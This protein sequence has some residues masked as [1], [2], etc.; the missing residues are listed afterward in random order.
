MIGVQALQAPELV[1]GLLI[2]EYYLSVVIK[3]CEPGL[4]VCGDVV[5]ALSMTEDLTFCIS[6]NCVRRHY[7]LLMRL[8]SN[9]SMS[10][11]SNSI[12]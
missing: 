3:A 8:H 9:R 12:L 4:W 10:D 1:E 6:A 5:V 2:K 11:D 7:T